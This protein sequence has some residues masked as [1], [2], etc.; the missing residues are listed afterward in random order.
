MSASSRR[1]LAPLR[2]TPQTVQMSHPTEFGQ[3]LLTRFSGCHT[4]PNGEVWVQYEDALAAL[5]LAQER[6]LR[7]LGMDGFV[8][9]VAVYPS[10]S[11]IADYSSIQTPGDAYD[12]AKALLVGP[13]AAVPDDLHSE[14]EGDYMIDLVVDE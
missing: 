1:S 11:R 12:Q 5:D 4:F 7:L 2:R 14:A 13:W 9:G 10:M 3:Q 8:V 6:G